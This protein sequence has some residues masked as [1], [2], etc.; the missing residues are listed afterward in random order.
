[1]RSCTLYTE[2]IDDLKLA[3]QEMA[4]QLK[5]KMHLG[6]NTCGIMFC[7]IE[8]DEVRFM[9]LFRQYYDFPIL[10]V[11]SVAMLESEVG[12]V[13]TGI[14]LLVMTA[15]DCCFSVGLTE[16]ITAENLHSCIQEGFGR[17]KE[18]G[19]GQEKLI[20]CYAPVMPHF[21]G[22]EIV[23][24]FSK[25][26][27]A[28]LFGGMASD[29]FTIKDNRIACNGISCRNR[30]GMVIITG[31]V[32]PLFQREYS[33]IN[34][35]DIMHEVTKSERNEVF[36]LENENFVDVLSHTGVNVE[37]EDVY[38]SFVGTVFEA[39]VDV[40]DGEKISVMRDL[41]V[42]NQENRSGVFLGNVPEGSK[43][44][45]CL[46]NKEDISSSVKR[47]FVDIFNQID[48]IANYEYSTFLISSCAG[49]FL[50]LSTEPDAEAKA[51]AD[52]LPDNISLCGFYSY[53]EICPT[54]LTSG[55]RYNVF[56]NKTF[57][58]VAF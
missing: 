55:R 8:T 56:H 18:K 13:D 31:N 47:S 46:L 38:L 14:C 25:I 21:T 33:I 12:Y 42:L 54:Y 9:E 51:Y 45:L 26:T 32:K 27:K 57:T 6:E 58:L 2:E 4:E 7:D 5:N 49:R 39:L 11:S 35:K 43:M 10:S 16:E 17:L 23:E 36:E 19:T 44:R 52:M 37:E 53:G 30:V 22:D 3:A 40:G 41:S 1:M 34:T 24:C 15:N 28:P 29:G 20:L 48:N 50:L